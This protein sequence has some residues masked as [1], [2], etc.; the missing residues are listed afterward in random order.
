MKQLQQFPTTY[1]SRS[2]RETRR[3]AKSIKKRNP[4]PMVEEGRGHMHV[5]RLLKFTPGCV[6]RHYLQFNT[7]PLVTLVIFYSV[8]LGERGMYGRPTTA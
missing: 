1:T 3:E 2:E 7:L 6:S 5:Y 4:L 8:W